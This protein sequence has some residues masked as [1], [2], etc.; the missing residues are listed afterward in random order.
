MADTTA[1]SRDT[2]PPSSVYNLAVVTASSKSV[3]VSWTAPQDD[4]GKIAGYD[5]RLSRGTLDES[6]W[7]SAIQFGGTPSDTRSGE[8]EQAELT[9]LPEGAILHIGIKAYDAAGNRSPLSNVI[10]V[11]TKPVTGTSQ[12]ASIRA[13]LNG[14]SASSAVAVNSASPS[15]NTATSDTGQGTVRVTIMLPNGLPSDLP[16]YVN[17]VNNVSGQSYGGPTINGLASY[18]IP[19]GDYFVRL[20]I[21]DPNYQEPRNP[22]IFHLDANED[23]D[24]GSISLEATSKA[25]GTTGLTTVANSTGGVTKLLMIII[26]MLGEILQVLMKT[27][28]QQRV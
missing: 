21:L 10:S 25:D 19:A 1:K 6:T 15:T 3:S 20:V 8:E 26:K 22:T 28:P 11:T 2:S 14:I 17:F 9:G 24:L 12:A 4:S 16:V 5:L 7:D 13:D 18:K 27:T 23:K